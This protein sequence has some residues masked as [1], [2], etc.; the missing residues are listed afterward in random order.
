MGT[1]PGND[2]VTVSPSN[3]RQGSGS[4]S[5]V[6]RVLRNALYQFAR[7]GIMSEWTKKGFTNNKC[8]ITSKSHLMVWK[9]TLKKTHNG[10][11]VN[12]Y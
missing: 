12:I 5:L 11:S 7:R 8:C 4:L 1:I 9:K 10:H 6:A 2:V 3:P